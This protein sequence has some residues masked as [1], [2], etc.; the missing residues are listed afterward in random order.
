MPFIVK[1]MAKE[2]EESSCTKLPDEI[3]EAL[4]AMGSWLYG[5]AGLDAR[6]NTALLKGMLP[7]VVCPGGMV[8]VCE[9][10][11]PLTVALLNSTAFGGFRAVRS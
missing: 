1:L 7:V 5:C 11:W 9:T 10:V 4:Y 6:L 3:M 2:L 8:M